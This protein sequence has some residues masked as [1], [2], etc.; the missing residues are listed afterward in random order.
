MLYTTSTCVFVIMALLQL[1]TERW[2]LKQREK[3]MALNS[4]IQ[5]EKRVVFVGIGIKC[6]NELELKKRAN[7]KVSTVCF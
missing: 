5:L 1:C 2:I 4:E 6:G 7:C 3:E